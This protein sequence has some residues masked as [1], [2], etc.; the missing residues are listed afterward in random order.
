[1]M[2]SPPRKVPK[3]FLYTSFWLSL[4]KSFMIVFVWLLPVATGNRLTSD[5][6]MLNTRNAMAAKRRI[7]VVPSRFIEPLQGLK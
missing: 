1:V 2:F 3:P 5:R 7:L 4:N 6:T